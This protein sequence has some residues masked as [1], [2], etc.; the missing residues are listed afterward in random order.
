[1]APDY[2]GARIGRQATGSRTL[3]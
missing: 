2:T 3:P 1:M